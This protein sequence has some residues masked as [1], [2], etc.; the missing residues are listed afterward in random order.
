MHNKMKKQIKIARGYRLYPKTQNQIA[1][2]QKMLKSDSDT[3]ISTACKFFIKEHKENKNKE[4]R[5]S[6]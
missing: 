2:I 3:A 5:I 6:K 4:L 1:R